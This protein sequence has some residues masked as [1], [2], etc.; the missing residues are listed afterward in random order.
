MRLIFCRQE[1]NQSIEKLWM[2]GFPRIENCHHEKI[3]PEES[4]WKEVIKDSLSLVQRSV[5]DGGMPV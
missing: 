3:L 1:Q 4:L 5:I 2:E